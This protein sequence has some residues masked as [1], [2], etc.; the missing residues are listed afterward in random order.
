MAGA[1]ANVER[2]R[3]SY[4]V[5]P[6]PVPRRWRQTVST[7]THNIEIKPEANTEATMNNPERTNSTNSTNMVNSVFMMCLGY[8]GIALCA[9][10]LCVDA[11][12]QT[13]GAGG[14]GRGGEGGTQRQQAPRKEPAAPRASAAV[15]DPMAAIERELPSL[16]LD[17]KLDNAQGALFDSFQRAVRDAAEATR[18]R[19]RRMSAFKFDDGSTVSAASIVA[20]VA[21][22]DVARASAMQS[23]SDKL[24]ALYTTFDA[25]Q[26][27][28]FDRRLMQSQRD[29]LGTS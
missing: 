2:L 20:T 21:E 17:L 10:A 13:G 3:Y 12:A 18:Q 27:R 15:S 5:W 26:R 19:A 4:I 24:E 6:Y 22:A 8:F 29:P 23:A 14:R 28:M 7:F 25:D 11:F 9:S 1:E 16:R